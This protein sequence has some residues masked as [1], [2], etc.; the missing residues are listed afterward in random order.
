MRFD[1][2]HSNANC[3]TATVLHFKELKSGRVGFA[4]P[5][6]REPS[7][8]RSWTFGIAGLGHAASIPRARVSGYPAD[9]MAGYWLAR[10]QAEPYFFFFPEYR[11]FA[12]RGEPFFR[13]RIPTSLTKYGSGSGGPSCCG[14]LL[15]GDGG[16]LLTTFVFSRLLSC[17][18]CPLS[19]VGASVIGA[20]SRAASS[21]VRKN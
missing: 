17:C 7:P 10:M 2:N 19:C 16:F 18:R 4:G 1:G 9:L 5:G 8:L 11:R 20:P 14:M 21:G 3:L 12:P 13:G 15:S 6:R